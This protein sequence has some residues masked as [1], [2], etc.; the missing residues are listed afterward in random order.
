MIK[1]DTQHPPLASLRLH[2]GIHTSQPYAA[3]THLTHIIHIAHLRIY[4]TIT[5]ITHT[6]TVIHHK[7]THHTAVKH[8]AY[9]HLTYTHHIPIHTTHT[10]L[11]HNTHTHTYSIPH[12]T[13]LQ[14]RSHGIWHFFLCGV[15]GKNQDVLHVRNAAPLRYI[16]A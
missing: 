3:I 10:S 6:K 8:I 13:H 1:Q 12:A 7:H 15:M 16:K 5:Y 11:I 2:M 9:R 4:Y 14:I